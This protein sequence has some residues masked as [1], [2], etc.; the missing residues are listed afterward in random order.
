VGS[1]RPD[2][3]HDLETLFL[4][5]DLCD[6]VEVQ[7][8]GVGVELAVSGADVGATEQNLA[9]RA[10][11]AYLAAAGLSE[12]PGSGVRIRLDKRIPAAAGLGGGSS[13]AAATLRALDQLFDRRVGHA[14]VLGI[15]AHLGS[16]V[17]FFLALT[18]LA[19]GRGRGELLEPLDP[20]PALPGLLVVPPIGVS[21]AEAYRALDRA[22]DRAAVPALKPLD[23]PRDWADV[24]GAAHNDFE[25]IVLPMHPEVGEALTALRATRPLIALLS[26]SG[27]A[28]FALYRSDHEARIAHTAMTALAH[29]RWRAVPFRTLAAWPEP[30]EL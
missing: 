17:P 4:G 9:A 3:Y 18:P 24:A 15:A 27:S 26:G 25:A 22:R 21:T 11:R 8:G 16:D 20:L 13:D 19:I 12:Q 6:V 28:C 10:A 2:G 7:R 1:R 14:D 29:G 5:I 30:A 23:D